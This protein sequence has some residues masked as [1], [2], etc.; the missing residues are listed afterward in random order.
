MITWLLLVS[1]FC[2]STQDP[3]GQETCEYFV[4]YLLIVCQH[5]QHIR[6]TVP[7]IA[8]MPD[9]IGS[10]HF[11]NWS[12]HLS[13]ECTSHSVRLRTR[14]KNYTI[15]EFHQ[16]LTVYCCYAFAG[17]DNSEK[18]MVYPQDRVFKV[19]S[20][21]TF[22]CVLP[23]GDVLD[24]MYLT[25]SNN[26][27][28]NT[29][30]ISNQTYALT[31]YLNQPSK[32]S[33]TDVRCES[34]TSDSG[35]CVYIGYPPGD[36]DLQCETRDLESV[37][38]H[39]TVWRSTHLPKLAT[40]YQLL[41]RYIIMKQY[42]N[43]TLTAENRLGKLELSDRADMTKRV[44][45]F[46]PERVAASTVNARNVSLEW[47][48]PVQQYRNLKITCQINVI[49]F[50]YDITF[51]INLAV[52]NDLIPNWTYNVTVRCA[53]QHFWKWSDWSST[54]KFHTKGDVPD[55]LDVWMKMKG[56]QTTIIWKVSQIS[57][58]A[59]LMIKKQI[60]LKLT[61]KLLSLFSATTSVNSSWIIG[62]NGSFSLSWS[63]SPKA[64][65][66]YIVDW[67]PT[68]GHCVVDWLRVPSYETNAVI[69]SNGV[70]YSLSI[71]ACTQGAPVLLERREG[72]V[73]EESKMQMCDFLIRY[74]LL[75]VSVAQKYILFTNVLPM[76]HRNTRWPLQNIEMATAG[77][78]C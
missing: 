23:A 59:L 13:L 70:R 69:F 8:V 38:C 24:K 76:L 15:K 3:N 26:V 43:W 57:R 78:R 9:Q 56:N 37:E 51:G 72:Y 6:H 62:N 17:K 61:N 20:R 53:T 45:M 7:Y 1:L 58:L 73:K 10:T 71:F 74:C 21:V 50:L 67:C 18:P 65:C 48:W 27:N 28:M 64:S 25:G 46:A 66:G 5:K 30:K 52:L 19:G 2:K 33:C 44:H 77:F 32:A 34:K 14:H 35:A 31:V 36:K 68:S 60:H 22:C 49:K 29:T 4:L 63:A 42:L 54:V 55:A 40:A 12:S 41:G 75:N 11:W 16:I 39:W 47:G